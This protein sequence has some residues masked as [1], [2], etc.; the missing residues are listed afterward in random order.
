MRRTAKYEAK[1]VDTAARELHQNNAGIG[2][3]LLPHLAQHGINTVR[4]LTS[5]LFFRSQV[6]PQAAATVTVAAVR[7]L[8]VAPVTQAASRIRTA[9]TDTVMWASSLQ[10]PVLSDGQV[11]I[12]HSAQIRL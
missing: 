8:V 11:R 5:S 10:M 7:A 3:N 6:V 1:T 4:R 2:L 12:V 9:A